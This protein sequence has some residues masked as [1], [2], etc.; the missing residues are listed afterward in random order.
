MGTD[1]TGFDRPFVARPRRYAW[2]GTVSIITGPVTMPAKASARG[3]GPAKDPVRAVA[4]GRERPAEPD[5]A[6][7]CPARALEDQG[8]PDRRK[9]DEPRP[10]K[11]ADHRRR[12]QDH[13]TRHQKRDAPLR[14]PPEPP[15]PARFAPARRTHG[16]AAVRIGNAMRIDGRGHAIRIRRGRPM[17]R[18]DTWGGGHR[19]AP[20]MAMTPAE[21]N[22]RRR[23]DAPDR[24][25]P[26]S[27]GA[28]GRR[29]PV[30]SRSRALCHRMACC[31]GRRGLGHP[32]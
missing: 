16:R 4:P 22:S 7:L 3:A 31:G 6:P 24:R 10:R 21:R 1:R 2:P 15:P 29:G 19:H 17:G 32:P 25:W 9:D 26:A 5:I 13:P 11:Q 12:Q 20:Q 8:Q 27:G 23:R 14:V 18:G 28:R 30:P